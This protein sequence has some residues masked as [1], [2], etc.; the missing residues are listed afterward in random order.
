MKVR[1]KYFLI[2]FAILILI[3]VNVAIGFIFGYEIALKPWQFISEQ[4]LGMQWLNTLLGSLI[5]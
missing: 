3:S 2:G 5:K 1:K 4:I